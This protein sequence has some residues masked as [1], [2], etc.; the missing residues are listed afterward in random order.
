MDC[1]FCKIISGD[2]PSKKAYEDDH[3]LAFYDIAPQAPVH[4]VLVP[5]DHILSAA[6][7]DGQN[8]YLIAHLFEA[9]AN[10]ASELSLTEGFRVVTN[11]GEQGGQTVAHLHFH[12]LAG[13][14]LTWPPG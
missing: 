8:S 11:C 12:L 14:N 1:L 4:I 13:R 2:I 6:A 5:K 10:I 7:I 9:V 3:V